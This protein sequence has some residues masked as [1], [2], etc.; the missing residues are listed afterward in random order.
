MDYFEKLR[1]LIDVSSDYTH[2]PL[3][4]MIRCAL[5]AAG[6]DPQLMAKLNIGEKANRPNDFGCYVKHA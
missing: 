1:K 5:S 2:L 6:F 4:E 3:E